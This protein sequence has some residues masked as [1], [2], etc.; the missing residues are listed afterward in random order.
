MSGGKV[1]PREIAKWFVN[2]VDRESGDTIS[3]L[4]LQ[5]L[6]YYA[7]AWYLANFDEPLFNE[8]IEAWTHGPVVPSVWD[9][10]KKHHWD[11]IP[12]GPDPKLNPEVVEYLNAVFDQYGDLSARVLEDM[13]HEESPWIEARGNLPLEAR[14]TKAI[15]KKSMRDFYG[16]E[17]GKIYNS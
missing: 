1:L 9:A 4:K 3:H 8:D 14:C 10:Y 7:Q 12:K 6:V 17:I 2:R 16:K 11:S 13:T 15:S 5:K